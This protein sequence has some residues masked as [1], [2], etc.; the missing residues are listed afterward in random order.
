MAELIMGSLIG[1]QQSS[2][3]IEHFDVFR[4]CVQDK[5]GNEIPRGWE[6]LKEQADPYI[7]WTKESLDLVCDAAVRCMKPTIDG[8]MTTKDLLSTL[9]KAIYSNAHTKFRNHVTPEDDVALCGACFQNM[10]SI[11]CDEGHVLCM[12]CVE[13]KIQ[14]GLSGGNQIVCPFDGCSS[15]PFPDECFYGPM[16]LDVYNLY[17]EKRAIKN[18]IG[19]L[20]SKIDHVSLQ[21]SGLTTSVDDMSKDVKRNTELLEEQLKRIDKL[22]LGLDR[23]MALLSWLADRDSKD[24]PHLVW[25]T[26][27]SVR[28]PNPKAWFTFAT[29]QRYKVVFICEHSFEP[30]HEPFEINM[31]RSWIVTM[32]PWLKLCVRVLQLS[33][34]CRDLPFPIPGLKFKDQCVAMN[35]FLNVMT[36]A[37]M[38]ACDRILDQTKIPTDMGRQ[39]RQCAGA[40]FKAIAEKVNEETRAK[41][42]RSKMV[43]VPVENADRTLIWVKR[44]HQREYMISAG[45]L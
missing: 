38:I 1:G 10:S 9:S 32:A 42:W 2:D 7:L 43:A 13:I 25:I 28:S 3:G 6:R 40:A 31:P 14:R 15:R 24:C 20:E 16:S 26:P 22:A 21:V 8:R 27:V 5:K 37:G 18:Y 36:E 30:G 34:M 11:K 19:N 17:I 12:T 33:L 45:S 23:N 29:Q 35:A 39:V 41:M 4:N 44:E